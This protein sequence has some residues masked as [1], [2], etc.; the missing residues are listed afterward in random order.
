VTFL[1]LEGEK[2]IQTFWKKTCR[3]LYRRITLTETQTREM[4]DQVL[5]DTMWEVV[6][7]WEDQWESLKLNESKIVEQELDVEDRQVRFW[8][9]RP[10]GFTVSEKDRVIYIVEFKR[11]STTGE[12]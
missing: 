6:R 9:R 4:T 10:D 3:E 11:V 1:T 5:D 12:K 2:S 7:P 8:R